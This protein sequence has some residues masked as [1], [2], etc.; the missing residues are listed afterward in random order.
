[1][2]GESRPLRD[3][4]R[5][6]ADDPADGF[7]IMPILTGEFRV[8]D[9]VDVVDAGP[10]VDAY[11]MSRLADETVHVRVGLPVRERRAVVLHVALP[12][13]DRAFLLALVVDDVDQ[14]A[15]HGHG[16]VPNFICFG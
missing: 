3:E 10:S 8:L 6:G 4:Q 13:R 12:D 15:I 2:K 5:G 16:S 7:G 11:W 14:E 1:M 9:R